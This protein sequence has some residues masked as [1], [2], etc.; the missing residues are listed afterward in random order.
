MLDA[1]EREVKANLVTPADATT[2]IGKV[3]SRLLSSK[4]LASQIAASL[5]SLKGIIDPDRSSKAKK[6]KAISEP[7]AAE[8][9]IRLAGEPS[10]E[11]EEG[12]EHDAEVE[13]QSFCQGKAYEIE[14]SG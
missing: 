6:A 11:D 13:C 3:Q 7:S 14:L 2:S 10:G 1:L 5:E 8:T 12:D 9:C 4:A